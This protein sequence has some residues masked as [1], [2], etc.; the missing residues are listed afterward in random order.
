MHFRVDDPTIRICAAPDSAELA[1]WQEI[2]CQANPDD[3][4]TLGCDVTI[5]GCGDLAV[6]CVDNTEYS[7]LW[8]YD[9]TDSSDP[10]PENR[11]KWVSSRMLSDNGLNYGH[12]RYFEAPAG[13]GT[14]M[15]LDT[16][17]Y[18][19]IDHGGMLH[20]NTVGTYVANYGIG[21]E[22]VDLGL[23]LPTINDVDRRPQSLDTWAINESL[24]MNIHLYYRDVAVVRDKI[25]AIA[26][27]IRQVTNIR[28][29]EIF[30][31]DL[32]GEPT[33]MAPLQNLPKRL[34]T[35]IDFPVLENETEELKLYDLA[36]VTGEDGGIAVVE[37]PVDGSDPQRKGFIPTPKGVV[38]KQELPTF[39]P[40]R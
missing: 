7:Y 38:T 15:G 8:S 4:D 19:D 11:I 20:Q 13:I 21:L 34:A 40:S 27:D 28:M 23:N 12:F 6:T 33:G 2:H 31:P 1:A 17:Q 29:L 36:F 3:P 22:L 35:V 26:S 9:V 16:L 14:T 10:V 32:S 25:V 39:Q 5:G 18:M 24:K 30:R 37:I